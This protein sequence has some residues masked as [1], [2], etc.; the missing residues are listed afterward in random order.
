M[1]GIFAEQ[2]RWLEVY[3]FERQSYTRIY[4]IREKQEVKREKER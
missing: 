2:S 3:L 4:R 1:E